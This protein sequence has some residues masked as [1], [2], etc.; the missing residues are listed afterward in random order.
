MIQI[1]IAIGMEIPAISILPNK[2]GMIG[3]NFPISIPITIHRITHIVRY[4]WKKLMPVAS[5]F[6]C[7]HLP[8]NSFFRF[9]FFTSSDIQPMTAKLPSECSEIFFIHNAS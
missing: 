4:F 9:S 2:S 8:Y 1:K 7:C 3:M 6:N 5:F